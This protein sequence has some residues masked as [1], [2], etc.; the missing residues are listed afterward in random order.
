MVV[1]IVESERIGSIEKYRI[2][3]YTIITLI[4]D[5]I[6]SYINFQT[7]L[8]LIL[9]QRGSFLMICPNLVPYTNFDTKNKVFY[10]QHHCRFQF[11]VLG[12]KTEQTDRVTFIY[13]INMDVYIET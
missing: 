2:H 1:E 13:N 7:S 3:T 8:T 4:L 10:V 11:S 9:D 6:D 5:R 12:L